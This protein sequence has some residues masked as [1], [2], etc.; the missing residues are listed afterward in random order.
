M[1][2]LRESANCPAPRWQDRPLPPAPEPPADPPSPLKALRILRSNAIAAFSRD[3]FDRLIVVSRSVLGAAAVVSDPD[4]IRRVLVDNTGNY[5]RDIVQQRMMERPFGDSLLGTED[6]QWRVQRRRLGPLFTPKAVAGLTAPMAAA[7]DALAERWRAYGDGSRLAIDVEMARLA[8]D[9]LERTLFVDGIKCE[10]DVF[11]IAVARH[12]DAIGRPDPLDLLN[13]PRWL[14]RIG[15]IRALASL[16][17]FERTIDAIIGTR[18]ARLAADPSLV[19][20]DLLSLLMDCGNS[21][22]G[23][24][25]SDAD[26]RSNVATF[27]VAG[28]YESTANILTWTLFLL[29]LDTEWQERLEAEA[30]RELPDGHYVE[31]SLDRLVATRAVIEETMRLY[32]PF[33]IM[34]RQ[35]LGPD[36]LGG[37]PIPAGTTVIIAPWVVHRHRLLWEEPER[38]DPARFLPGARESI[39]RFAYIPFGIG[40]RVCIG[41]AFGLQQMIIVL[42]SILRKFKLS[43]A[44]GHQ[45]RPVQHVTLHPQG[46]MPM[47]LHRRQPRF[48]RTA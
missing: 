43:L 18:K 16:A 21:N 7:A 11:G 5:H 32:P 14:P 44:P 25:L 22:Q 48:A 19:P 20:A 34:S 2:A 38:F 23:R 31:G 42:A 26:I 9:I 12:F 29:S 8:V 36:T 41:A 45:V 10:P 1:T 15:R 33:A 4:A 6:D 37:Q 39:G 35:A 27:I 13:A 24:D 3:H 46:G 30:D 28:S 40:P 17:L 47:I